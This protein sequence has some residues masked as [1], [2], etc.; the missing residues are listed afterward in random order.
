MAATDAVT[1]KHKTRGTLLGV[2][3]PPELNASD[4]L[5]NGTS[6]SSR[7]P[8]GADKMNMM[9]KGFTAGLAG[10][11]KTKVQKQLKADES[12]GD[13]CNDSDEGGDDD[14]DSNFAFKVRKK[15]SATNHVELAVDSSNDGDSDE[16]GAATPCKRTR[17]KRKNHPELRPSPKEKKTSEK[18][19]DRLNPSHP[20]ELF[21]LK[22]R[23]KHFVDTTLQ[24]FKV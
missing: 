11:G 22:E 16:D 10:L 23:Y 15:P 8:I 4:I 18:P 2:E 7:A 24:S 19:T 21:I 6:S 3:K 12:A 20:G 9:G 17:E 14:G 13:D 1:L 5:E